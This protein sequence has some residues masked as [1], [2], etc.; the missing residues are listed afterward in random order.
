MGQTVTD[1]DAHKMRQGGALL[2]TEEAPD[3]ILSAG[4]NSW[5]PV[6]ILAN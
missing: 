6:D 4:C 2:K 5:V 1:V 3:D